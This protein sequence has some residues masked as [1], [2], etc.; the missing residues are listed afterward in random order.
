M[1]FMNMMVN[2]MLQQIMEFPVMDIATSEFIITHFVGTAGE[3][4]EVLQTTALNNQIYAV[5]QFWN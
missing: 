4:T 1:I 2:Y 5:T 3:E